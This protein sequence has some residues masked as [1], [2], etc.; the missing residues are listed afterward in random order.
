MS[1]EE[2][3]RHHAERRDVAERPDVEQRAAAQAIDEPEAD[4]REHQVRHTDADRLQQRG[5]V[6]EAGELEDARR[7]VQDCVDARELVEERDQECEHDRHTQRTC[8][9]TVGR[10]VGRHRG[11]DFCRS[12]QDLRLG[13]RWFD[14]AQDL[15]SFLPIACTRQQPARTFG[16]R[17]AADGID[18]RRECRHAKHPAP[19][20]LASAGQQRIRQERDQNTKD[21]VELE[22]AREQPATIGRRDLGD[23]H[24][25]RDRRGAD[26]K[27]T[28][29]ACE[30][31]RVHVT[32]ERRPDGTDEIEYADE[33]QRRLASPFVG[34]PAAEHGADD[35]AIERRGHRDAMHAGTESPERLDLLLRTGDH[36]GVEAEQESG[37]RRRD[38]PEKDARVHG[39]NEEVR[40]ARTEA[41]RQDRRVTGAA[42]PTGSA[43][44]S[45]RPCWR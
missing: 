2:R 26:A 15:Q 11:R 43:G 17:E 22:H 45:D 1:R 42:L 4:E 32:R 44:A 13:C 19:R 24:R 35:G 20:V 29:R 9:E 41:A 23:V 5:L 33:A 12:R 40:V 27:A 39:C 6:T 36:H 3:P 30:N 10:R 14:Q 28:D 37:K 31:E 16:N 7:E 25:R 38:G 18:H 34:G 21:D 8:P